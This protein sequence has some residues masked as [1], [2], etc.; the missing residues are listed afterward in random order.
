MARFSIFTHG[1]KKSEREAKLATHE[2]DIINVRN[3]IKSLVLRINE[4]R[5]EIKKSFVNIVNTAKIR[6]S[7]LEDL[8]KQK[9]IISA[10]NEKLD[11]IK[12][13]LDELYTELERQQMQYLKLKSERIHTNC[14]SA[15]FNSFKS[16]TKSRAE[17]ATSPPN[18][19]AVISSACVTQQK[20]PHSG[21]A[22]E[23]SHC[24]LN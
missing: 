8:L 19:L 3:G 2:N 1:L 15:N 5:E 14:K 23:K 13:K 16:S 7:S 17:T 4:T 10:Y 12:R 24:M 20:R 9:K 22:S 18:P 6:V 11:K 21:A